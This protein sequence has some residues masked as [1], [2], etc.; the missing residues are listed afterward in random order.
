MRIVGHVLDQISESFEHVRLNLERV[1][2]VRRQFEGGKRR[3]KIITDFVHIAQND[4]AMNQCGQFLRNLAEF[5][6][7]IAAIDRDDIE[8]EI[9]VRLAL[10]QQLEKDVLTEWTCAFR[11]AISAGYE[12]ANDDVLVEL[13]AYL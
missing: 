13:D 9:V 1:G 8:T 2:I 6:G 10:E 3:V 11:S 4:V 12:K 5:L 7:R